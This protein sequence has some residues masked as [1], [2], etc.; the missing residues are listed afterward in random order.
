MRYEDDRLSA[1][2]QKLDDLAAR[3]ARLETRAA[4]A[5][6]AAPTSAPAGRG[7]RPVARPDA[8]AGAE[9][10]LED[11]SFTAFWRWAR[12]LGY[13]N[14]DAIETL[15]GRSITGLSPADLRTLVRTAR[16]ET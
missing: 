14:K 6:A 8:G 4:P 7:L 11:Y 1:V 12:E 9:P 2:E 15:I 10:A 16:G 3:V 5:P 13:Q